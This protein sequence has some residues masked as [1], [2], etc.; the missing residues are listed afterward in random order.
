M[1]HEKTTPRLGGGF[2]CVDPRSWRGAEWSTQRSCFARKKLYKKA[3]SLSGLK[4]GVELLFMWSS[5][6]STIGEQE[7]AYRLSG[8]RSDEV[9]LL[10]K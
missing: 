9:F 6:E 8:E 4:M 10:I 7:N 3:H 5:K 2:C 1:K